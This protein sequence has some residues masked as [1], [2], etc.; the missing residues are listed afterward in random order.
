MTVDELL[1]KLARAFPAFN[2]RALETWAPVYRAA[3]E[4]HE[5][6]A[7]RDAF[8]DVLSSFQGGKNKTLFP[9]VAD[10]AARLPDGRLKLPSN[11]PALDIRGHSSRA[12]SLMS[13]W[14]AGQGLRGSKGVREVLLAL[15][16]IARPIAE[17]SAWSE[18]PEPIVLTM[19]QLKLAQHRAISQQRRAEHGPPGKDPEIWWEQ[20]SGIA[21]R[22]GIETTREEWETTTPTTKQEAAAKAALGEP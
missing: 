22:W 14:R 20:I 1:D 9:T 17:N 15:E 2:A 6:P 21:K 3:L 7:L 4:K 16:F 10:F 8:M 11:G 13:V 19:K 12:N 18:N 5:G